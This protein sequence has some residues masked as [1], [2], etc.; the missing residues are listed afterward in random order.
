MLG[1]LLNKPIIITPEQLENLQIKVGEED[2][3]IVVVLLQDYL[4][5][6]VIDALQIIAGDE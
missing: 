5:A 6:K 4:C 1:N 2:G 3:A